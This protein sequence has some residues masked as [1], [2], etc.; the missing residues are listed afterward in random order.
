MVL[1]LLRKPYGINIKCYLQL[2]TIVFAFENFNFIFHILL[3][4][5]GCR[6]ICDNYIL[7]ETL[8]QIPLNCSEFS[9]SVMY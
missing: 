1:Q 3:F 7:R 5:N 9:T 4:L 2:I 6:K 8:L